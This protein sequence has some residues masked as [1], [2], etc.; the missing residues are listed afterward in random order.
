MTR[1]TKSI[2]IVGSDPSVRYALAAELTAGGYS[3]ETL[4][5]LDEA[6]ALFRRDLPDLLVVDLS[7]GERAAE[8]IE[9]VRTSSHAPIIVVSSGRAETERA[10]A[11]RLGASDFLPKPF[12]LADLRLRV[13]AQLRMGPLPGELLEFSGLTI[14]S[15]GRRVLRDQKELPL[16]HSEYAI[17]ELLAR[18]AGRPFSESDISTHVWERPG[19]RDLVRAHFASL[20]RKLEPDAANPRF[21]VHE[22][23]LG[24]RFI[25]L[26]LRDGR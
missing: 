21:V 17:L 20:R 23:W 22:P 10:R 26:P 6:L 9:T 8:V 15:S 7:I 14:D 18:H 4:S 16:N 11:M 1:A 13:D 3:V 12:S 2:L 19:N 5:D 25:A 24:Y